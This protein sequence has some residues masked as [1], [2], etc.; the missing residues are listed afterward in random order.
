[1]TY[2]EWERSV[3]EHIRADPIWSL[4]IYRTAL[5]AGEQG[6]RDA[7][8]LA[9]KSG[10]AGLSDQL[11][12]ATESISA[13]ISEG[14]SRIGAKDRGKFFEYALGSARE[15]RDW[16]FKAREPLGEQATLA[17]ITLMTTIIK[18]LT[19]FVVKSRR[20]NRAKLGS[21]S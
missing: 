13:N 7:I 8:W 18:I 3:P 10:F 5:Y 19:V 4:R 6:R 21:E 15:S 14:Y 9:G 12:R 11:A 1:M 20:A 16:Y 17:R 2:E